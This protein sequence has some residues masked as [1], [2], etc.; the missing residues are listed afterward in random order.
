[1]SQLLRGIA[2][3]EPAYYYYYLFRFVCCEDVCVREFEKTR[4]CVMMEIVEREQWMPRLERK[5]DTNTIKTF[6]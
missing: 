2:D 5:D 6:R 1:M 3:G 4:E